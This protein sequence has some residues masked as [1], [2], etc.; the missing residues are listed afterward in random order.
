MR[1]FI[2][3]TGVAIVII[4]AVTWWL[5][6]RSTSAV[7]VVH[8]WRGKAVQ[9]AYATGTVEATVMIPIAPRAA[10]RLEKLDADEGQHVTKGQVLASLEGDALKHSIEELKAKEAF[11]KSD[12]ERNAQ[13]IKDRAASKM[14]YDRTKAEWDAATAAVNKAKAELEYTRLVAPEDGYI[15]KRDGEEGEFIPVNQPVFWMSCCE[16]FRVTAEVDEEDIPQVKVGQEVLIRADAFPGKIFHGSVQ[17]ITPKGDPVSRSYR[18]RVSLPADVPLLIG[19]TAETNI[20]LRED[21][22]AM[23]VP[24]SAVLQDKVWVVDGGVLRQKFVEVGATGA[25]KIEIISGLSEADQ[26]VAKPQPSFA[27]GQSV[28]ASLVTQGE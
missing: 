21:D 16:P 5:S 28:R 10:A 24:A 27:D 12:Y 9:A 3:F 6:G 13:L 8:P 1:N 25:D 7:D 20:I 23:L 4:A 2:L 22:N 14:E 18:V 19:M 26:V 15:I 17:S 11:A